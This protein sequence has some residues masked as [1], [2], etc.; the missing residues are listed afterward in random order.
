MELPAPKPLLPKEKMGR[1]EL[2]WC[3]SGRKWKNC[4]RDRGKERAQNVN[5]LL[6]LIRQEQHRGHCAHPEASKEMC[7]GKVTGTHTIQKEGGLRA[8]AEDGHVI[9]I[10][11]A[12]FGIPK[13]EGEIVPVLE[14]I[15]RASI[16]PG[17]CNNHDATFRPA[18]QSTVSLGPEVAF[19][20]SYRAIVYERFIK[21]AALRSIEVLRQ[22]ADKGLP[23]SEQIN[24][25]DLL[26]HQEF[27]IKQGLEDLKACNA[28]F[29]S[30]YRASLFGFTFVAVEF[31]IVLPVVSCGAFHPD[32]DLY[33]EALQ[34]LSPATRLDQ[35]AV[36]LTV[37]N[38]RSVLLLGWV[39]SGGSAKSFASSY[40]RLPRQDKANTAVRL[41][42]EYGENT[43]ARPSWW[44][45]LPRT[46]RDQV[47]ASLFAMSAPGVCRRGADGLCLDG[48]VFATATV[49]K[50][51]L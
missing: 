5:Q 8:I 22:E 31:S 9:S 46:V 24:I 50:E 12:A 35:L 32:F 30:A 39:G 44:N 47:V 29:D 4:H 13:N 37:L 20:L 42:I 33:G 45:N 6:N 27:G 23:F 38:D 19:L 41:A 2:C 40:A 34:P 36:N 10:K 28:M 1:N 17:F 21:E 43:Y 14:G 51:L 16:F 48:T 25:Q 11:K 15:N 3:R 7:S 49:S 18:E 26:Y